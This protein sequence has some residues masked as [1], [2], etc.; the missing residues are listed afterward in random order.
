MRPKIAERKTPVKMPFPASLAL[1]SSDPKKRDIPR[2][3]GSTTAV[4]HAQRSPLV[5]MRWVGVRLRLFSVCRG[6]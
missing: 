1:E 5:A 6:F 3:I 2:T 4:I